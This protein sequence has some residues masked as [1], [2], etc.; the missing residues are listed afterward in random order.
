MPASDSSPS[1]HIYAGVGSRCTPQ[2]V[3]ESITLAATR[4]A[5]GGWT[6][7][8]GL[9]PGADQAFYGGAVAG[10]GR[11]ELYLPC[12]DFEA[13]A[14]RGGEE[15]HVFVL[16]EPADAAYSLAARF[17]PGF[18]ALSSHERRLRARDVHQLL[19][20]D[21]AE[22]AALVICW[23]PDGGVDGSGRHAGG[24][25][26][27][28]RIAHHHGVPVLNLSRAGHRRALSRQP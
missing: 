7:R 16:P 11:V 12:A 1:D 3:L 15:L 4:L 22:P 2:R 8:T 5:R 14:R 13:H 26:Q 17:H 27:A 6:L 23:T 21:L 28:L 25:G 10:R 20:R 9:S 19:G 24:T 18:P